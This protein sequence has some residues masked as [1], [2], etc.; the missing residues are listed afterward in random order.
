MKEFTP[1]EA[2][3]TLGKE[4]QWN[5]K[6]ELQG[7]NWNLPSFESAPISFKQHGQQFDAQTQFL[8]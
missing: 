7:E 1:D 2:F 3:L 4:A 6:R 5:C 8:F